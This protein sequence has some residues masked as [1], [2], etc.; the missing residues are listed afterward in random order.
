MDLG[1][2]LGDGV[3]DVLAGAPVDAALAV[4]ADAELGLV[5]LEGEGLLRPGRV[6]AAQRHGDGAGPPGD[7]AAHVGDHADVRAAGGRRAARLL[8]ENRRAGVATAGAVG[9]AAFSIGTI[10]A[11]TVAQVRG[12]VVADEHGLHPDALFGGQLRGHAEVHDVARVVLHD[13][14]HAGTVVDCPGG[15]EDLAGIRRGEDVPRAHGVEHARAEK[16]RMQWFVAGAAAGYQGDAF[17]SRAPV[18]TGQLE[19]PTVAPGD[20]GAP[21]DHPGNSQSVRSRRV[22]EECTH[23]T[24]VR[25]R[26]GSVRCVGGVRRQAKTGSGERGRRR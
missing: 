2:H 16:T 3:G 22:I 23:D 25:A 9:A 15:L 11:V 1:D 26:D 13:V 21:G 20:V 24:T 17:L 12:D 8:H 19:E 5:L 10:P 6:R 18:T 14:H 7:V 4:D